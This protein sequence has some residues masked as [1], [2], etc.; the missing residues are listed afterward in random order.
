MIR[1]CLLF[2]F[3][4][5]QVSL[6]QQVVGQHP[7]IFINQGELKDL[8]SRCRGGGK[9]DYARVKADA[10]RAIRGG[11][12]FVDNR[13][14]IPS[15]LMNCGLAYLVE[16]EKKRDHKKYADAIIK[17]WGDGSMISK[18]KGSHFGYHAIA[19][20]WIYDALSQSQRKTYGNALGSWLKWYTKQPRITLQ[21]GS[22]WYNQTWGPGHLN[23][24]HSRDAIT[25]KLLVSL[26]ILGGGSQ[27]EKDAKSFI[28]SWARRIP[29]E[30]IPAF[31][32]MGGVW[33][34][35]SGH[36][37][38]GPVSVIPYAFAAWKSATGQNLFIAGKPWSFLKEES[39]WL[40]YLKVPYVDRLA[41]VDDSSGSK[42]AGFGFCAPMVA[43]SL[44]DPLAQWMADQ[45]RSGFRYG[46]GFWQRVI[47]YDPTVRPK[48]P[49]KLQMPLAYCFQGAGH[50]YMRSKWN[51]PNATWAFFGV[52]P[53]L[54][55]H[56]HDD[57]G[58][59]LI[60]Q[61]GALVT[62]GGGTSGNDDDHY[63]GGSLV[64]NIVTIFDPKEKFRRN[65]Q[66]ENDGGLRRHVYTNKEVQR[67]RLV[68]YQ[69]Q[70][71]FT[72]A[73]GDITE[74][75]HEDK[76]R[77]VTRQLLYLR[78]DQEFVVVFDRVRSTKSSFVKHFMLHIPTK[79]QVNGKANVEVPDHVIA[80][81]SDS[82]VATW[83][84]LPDDYGSQ[85]E[86]LSKGRSR[87]FMKTVLPKGAIL[88]A[89]GGEGYDSW[90]HPLEK[91]AQYNHDRAGGRK[92]KKTPVAPWRLEVA[93]PRSKQ[94][95]FLHVF[96]IADER[97]K[98]MVPV[99]I[100]ESGSRVRVRFGK[101]GKVW[102]VTF[103]GSGKLLGSLKSPR[104]KT[105]RLEPALNLQSQYRFWDG[106]VENAGGK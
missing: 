17:L 37:G 41:F 57:E 104:K 64:F 85:V 60:S 8:V 52:G 50:V 100:L 61:R 39:R 73:A 62:K 14:A 59:F 38:Y 70:K 5:P 40:T 4:C 105:F 54:A 44:C 76:A 19:Y 69:H 7:R 21:N 94:T 22:W 101:P 77:E 47:A 51:D 9:D 92:R 65:R 6:S 20:D 1:I 89:R 88:T 72:Y 99:K 84:S 90:G 97:T 103:A 10:D 24:M 11:I 31:D 23:V 33:A 87:M 96:Q 102:E 68:G 32:K 46:R 25:Q 18:K 91:T 66:N 79:P 71:E 12:R 35:S 13:Y 80:Y 75:Y 56:A 15:D 95:Y 81:Q 63:W 93:A 49:K 3:L 55:G 48:S 98:K 26:A 42:D 36:G 45:A 30:C 28:K 86:V 83:L 2:L 82:L 74:G 27:Y 43:K 78:G 58:H 67:G 34:E 53:H 16:K 29:N 106:V